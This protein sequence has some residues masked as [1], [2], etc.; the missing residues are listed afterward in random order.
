M[1]CLFR[2][3]KGDIFSIL[4]QLKFIK[5]GV[6]IQAQFLSKNILKKALNTHETFGSV[7][8]HLTK[9]K[10]DGQIKKHFSILEKSF[11]N[12]RFFFAFT[13]FETP[14]SR[15]QDFM[16]VLQSITN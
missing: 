14:L 12:L 8:P 1:N 15:A 11:S 5:Y 4:E 6:K 2:H 3:G 13:S 16:P 7:A 10:V 9:I